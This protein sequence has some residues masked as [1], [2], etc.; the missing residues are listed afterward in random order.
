MTTDQ[1]PTAEPR[2]TADPGVQPEQETG[3]WDGRARDA[4]GVPWWIHD[5][6]MVAESD[7]RPGPHA[8]ESC[9]NAPGPWAPL[10]VRPDAVAV[11]A[12]IGAA[13]R[14]YSEHGFAAGY[15]PRNIL[16]RDRDLKAAVEALGGAA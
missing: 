2:V 15:L 6:G 10:W 4:D 16:G 3:R 1:S 12:L 8:C 5:C 13:R 7:E 9:G 14:W 11:R